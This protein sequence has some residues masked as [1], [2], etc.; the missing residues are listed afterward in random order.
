M[1][2]EILHDRAEAAQQQT[3]DLQDSLW[4]ARDEI[5]EHQIHHEDVDARLQQSKFR[6]M[7][8]RARIRRL[9]DLIGIIMLT[10]IQGMN[11][12][13]IEQLIA[14]HVVD[15]MTTY[16]ANRAS[17]NGTHNEASRSAGG[18]EHTIELVFHISNRAE[19]RQVKFA[20]CTLLDSVLTWWNSYVKTIRLD[21]AYMTT[22]KEMKQMM[23]NEYC[24]R[25]EIQKMES[26]L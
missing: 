17:R 1:E 9:E 20:A 7:E 18:V 16:E 3:E 13:S 15:A 26:E 11:F 4:R 23:I 6:E 24:Q 21:A 22:C 10:T 8:H 5:V 25:N 19:N 12:A 2:V 14:Q